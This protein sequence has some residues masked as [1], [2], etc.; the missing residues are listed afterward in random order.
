MR[1]LS[2]S[3][4]LASAALLSANDP[5]SSQSPTSYPWCSRGGDR[6]NSSSYYFV[7]KEQCKITTSGIGAYCFE[8]P[9]YQGPSQYRG[10][11]QARAKA[12]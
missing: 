6:S 4:I 2:L 5:A 1:L 8:N 9:Q 11:R 10:P 7:S 3:L 12:Q